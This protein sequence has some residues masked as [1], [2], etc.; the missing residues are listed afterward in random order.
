MYKNSHIIKIFKELGSSDGNF[1]IE[2]IDK[3]NYYVNCLKEANGFV[4]EKINIKEL[5]ELDNSLN[6]YIENNK[7]RE[8]MD[9]EGNKYTHEDED[10]YDYVDRIEYAIDIPP[11]IALEKE[12]PYVLDGFNRLLQHYRNENFEIEM[13][14]DIKAYEL[15]FEKKLDLDM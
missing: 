14:I 11:I 3:N 4:L 10:I 15:F 13:Y 5:K 2:K 1:G 6:E 12:K 9:D 8:Y 7:L